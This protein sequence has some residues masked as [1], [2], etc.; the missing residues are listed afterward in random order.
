MTE[1]TDETGDKLVQQV[2]AIAK[3]LECN[4]TVKG[5]AIAIED[6]LAKTG[7]LP[8]I[9]RRADQLSSFCLEYGLGVTFERADGALLGVTMNFDNTTPTNLRLLCITDVLIE[10]MQRAPTHKETPLDELMLD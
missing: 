5:E 2:C 9:M 6:A 1:N 4:F 7:L 3:A 8:A 10:I